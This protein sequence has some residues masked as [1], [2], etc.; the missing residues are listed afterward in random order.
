VTISA[1]TRR[2]VPGLDARLDYSYAVLQGSPLPQSDLRAASDS[3]GGRAF[4][5]LF[6][7]GFDP[8]GRYLLLRSLEIQLAGAYELVEFPLKHISPV[9]RWAFIIRLAIFGF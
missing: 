1:R 7:L 4:T 5:D 9:L 2:E 6:L 8:V 3:W